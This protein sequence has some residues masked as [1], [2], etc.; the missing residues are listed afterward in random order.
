MTV[1][2]QNKLRAVL[3]TILFRTSRFLSENVKIIIN[4]T[5]MLP[6]VLCGCETWCLTLREEH[7]LRMF[8]NKALKR[9]LGHK[10][11]EVIGRW[12][13]LGN[14]ELHNLYSAPN[15]TVIKSKRMRWVGYEA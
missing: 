5:I 8:E 1:E 10:R 2:N 14:E 4:R 11:E 9:T 6:V 15:I 7:R 12:R 3:A 13:K